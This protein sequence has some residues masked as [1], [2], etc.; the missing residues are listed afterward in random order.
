MTPRI[1]TSTALIAWLAAATPSTRGEDPTLASYAAHLGAAEATFRLGELSATRAWLD[2]AP[3]RHRG[4]EWL[5]LDARLDESLRSIRA[6]D[7]AIWGLDV[8]PDGTHLAIGDA[9][10]RVRV[11]DRATG[12]ETFAAHDHTDLVDDVRFDP[13]GERL[14]SASHDRTVRVW[15]LEKKENTLVFSQH[16]FP[17]G[18]AAFTRDGAS[19]LSAGYERNWKGKPVAGVVHRFRADDG[20]LEMTYDG[21]GNKPLTALAISRDGAHVAVASWDF[22]AFGW[23]VEEGG[24]PTQYIVP[25]E[26][27]Y[28]AVDCVA[29]SPDGAR[30]A[31]GGK[32]HA[33]RIHDVASGELLL[34]LRGHGDDVTGI[35]FTTDGERI[36]TTCVDSVV[37]VFDAANGELVCSMRGATPSASGL[38]FTPDDRA[39]LVSTADG[40]VLEFDAT[41]SNYGAIRAALPTAAYAV[42]FSPDG[43]LLASCSHDGRVQ[44][45]STS[46]FERVAD[47]QAH[48][49][50]KC[51]ITLAFT[52]DGDELLSCSYDGTIR[53]WDVATQEERGRIEFGAGVYFFALAPDGNRIA[54]ALTNK[55]TALADRES[56]TVLHRFTDAA[57]NVYSLAFDATQSR[58]LAAGQDRRARVYDLAANALT[59]ATEPTPASIQAAIF[60]SNGAT[61]V[62]GGDDGVIREFDAT[63]GKELRTI[64]SGSH[65]V[66]RLA[67]TRDGSRLVAAGQHLWFL[68]PL[69]GTLVATLRVTPE[70]TWDLEFSPDGTMLATADL[71]DHVSVLS[72][73]PMRARPR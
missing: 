44:L 63:T 28:N 2:A 51:A 26:G 20:E 11:L 38:V 27:L 43:K 8:S 68:E 10:G 5:V 13:S 34:T 33:A 58:L 16:R 36:A 37:R 71:D 55:E 48:E 66:N 3:S 60:S 46:N 65:A 18:G 67:Y 4:F 32:D 47:W 17:V 30:I 64:F 9:K 54:A 21:G 50:S 57:A 49:R 29:Y 42:R 70:A 22:C 40:R 62:T 15:D 24:E 31:Y 56:G 23:N 45:F 14:V 41:H 39:L 69:S 7:D 12:A 72:A 59:C 6:S 73:L 52:P 25:D 35:A 61:F 53:R 19:I 1:T